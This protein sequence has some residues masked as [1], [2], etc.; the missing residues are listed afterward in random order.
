MFGK[1]K[2]LSTAAL[3]IAFIDSFDEKIPAGPLLRYEV[4]VRYSNA[5]EIR[6]SFESKVEAIRFLNELI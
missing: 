2:A 6:A 5:D 4:K 1:S 3:A